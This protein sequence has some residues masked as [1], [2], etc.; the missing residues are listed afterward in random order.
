MASFPSVQQLREEPITKKGISKTS[1]QMGFCNT[2]QSVPTSSHPVSVCQVLPRASLLSTCPSLC[3]SH[4][5]LILQL[6]PAGSLTAGTEEEETV[7]HF[8]VCFYRVA[9]QAG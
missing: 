6:A 3:S 7:R 5:G 4:W 2:L 1:Q 8:S 9:L